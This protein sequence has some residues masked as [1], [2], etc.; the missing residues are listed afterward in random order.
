M[1]GPGVCATTT[2]DNTI[3]IDPKRPILKLVLMASNP[4]LF[5]V[6]LALGPPTSQVTGSLQPGLAL[7]ARANRTLGSFDLVP[8]HL[9]GLN[10]AQVG[11]IC[12]ALFGT[13]LLWHK[14]T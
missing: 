13:P 3:N 7:C 12:L 10:V 2:T 1:T 6:S 4:P 8:I 9:R 14:S 5:A 11:A